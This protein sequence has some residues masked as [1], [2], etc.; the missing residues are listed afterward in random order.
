MQADFRGKSVSH[1]GGRSICGNNSATF[2]QNCGNFPAILLPLEEDASPLEGSH[3]LDEG[4]V[5]LLQGEA[6]AEALEE[7]LVVFD[8]EAVHELAGVVRG[9][10]E[11]FARLGI[12]PAGA[13][14][15]EDELAVLHLRYDL[16]AVAVEIGRFENV[17]VLGHPDFGGLDILDVRLC[18]N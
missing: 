3:D 11:A 6:L 12:T 13:A 18:H 15:E 17:P 7:G 9:D 16:V 1:S 10:D 8:L 4:V 2:Y 14:A 5:R